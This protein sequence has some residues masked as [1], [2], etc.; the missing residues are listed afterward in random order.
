MKLSSL[1]REGTYLSSMC[2]EDIE[3]SGVSEHTDEIRRGDLFIA[4]RGNRFDATK[5]LTKI[6]KCGACAVLLPK[7]SIVDAETSLPIF[8]AEDIDA[9]AAEIW[10]RYYL[11]PERNMRFI[12]VTGTNGKTTT[13]LMLTHILEESGHKTAYIGTLGI[14]YE[15]KSYPHLAEGHMTTPSAKSLFHALKVLKEEGCSTVVMEVSSHA[16]VKK[17]C[18][19]ISFALSVF[20]GLTEDHLDF[21]KTMEDYYQAK[22]RLFE[23]SH[24]SLINVDDAY[25]ERLFAEIAKKKE[26]YA[27]LRD[28]DNTLTDLNET[29]PF[30]TKYTYCTKSTSF[31]IDYPLFGSFNLYNSLAAISAARI[32][33]VET[34]SIQKAMYTLPQIPGRMERLSTPSPFSVIIDYAHTPDAMMQSIRAVKK[35]TPRRVIVL[36]GAGGER[37][38]EKRA[39]MG[40]IAEKYADFVFVTKDNSRSE[41][42]ASIIK[43]ILSGIKKEEVR[44]VVSSREKAIKEALIMAKEGDT[45]LLLGKGHEGYMIGKDGVTPFDEREIVASFLR[46]KGTSHGV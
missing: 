25:G 17:R 26:S 32:L 6:E 3:I 16:L 42:T 2:A 37:E 30:R 11:T 13:A 12:A 43:D 35:I 24:I 34:K 28:C 38:K 40:S 36:F 7:D 44:R 1:L 4:R 10:S 18:E 19:P 39:V 8:Y 27:V 15:K 45:V 41:S 22:K 5:M 20:T 23:R 21:H 46:E 29:A 33:G 31:A 14:I 9:S